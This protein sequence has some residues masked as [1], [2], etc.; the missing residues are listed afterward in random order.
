MKSKHHVTEQGK[1]LADVIKKAIEDME[2]TAAE[3]EEIVATAH[4]DGH[5]DP[6]EEQ[7]LHELH[8]MIAD[9]TVKR[10]RG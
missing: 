9:G 8:R 2:I 1:R 5:I 4:E 7:L 10:V 3:Y 6:D